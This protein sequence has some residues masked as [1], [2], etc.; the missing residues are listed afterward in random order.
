V[1]RLVLLPVLA[2]LLVPTAA[3]AA[4]HHVLLGVYGPVG[5]FKAETGQRSQIHQTFMG[6]N[7][8]YVWGAVKSLG[9]IPLL[10]L[11][12]GAYGRP[13]TASPRQIATGR[14]DSFLYALNDAI[15]RWPGQRFYL[16]PFPEMN[17]YWNN[18]CA[19]NANGTRR[20][21][22]H[23]TAWTRKAFARIALVARGG[24]ADE[25][26]AKLARLG[27]PGVRGDLPSTV[28]K[29]RIVWNPQGYGNPRVSGNSAAA[30]FPG[31]AY[32]DVVGDDLY[33][34]PGHG[35]TWAAAEALYRAHRAKPFAVPEWG[36]W[37]FDD[38]GY[39]SEMAR[40]ARTH[41]RLEFISYYFAARGSRFDLASKPR[42]RAVYRRQIVPLGT[43]LP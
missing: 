19:Y 9:P 32:V 22:A 15:N 31:N 6:F 39:V 41:P 36:L 42:S 38:P 8:Q 18:V 25:L 7:H 28:P 16:R 40:F 24:T 2:L 13:E 4:K 37:G 5:S 10:A 26:N 3:S 20:N 23:S 27:L 43:T 17:A 1:R 21:A 12:S 33:D 30:Y 14:I 34:M 35:A 29:L 11:T